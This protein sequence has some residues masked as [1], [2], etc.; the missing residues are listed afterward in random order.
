MEKRKFDSFAEASRFARDVSTAS[1]SAVVHRFDG[2][3]EVEYQSSDRAD[4]RAHAGHLDIQQL[5]HEL[6]DCRVLNESLLQ[7][8][9]G[10]EKSIEYKD[11]IIADI[12]REIENRVSDETS[13]EREEIKESERKRKDDYE[14]LIAKFEKER[15]E[16]IDGLRKQEEELKQKE[17]E[18]RS[19][20]CEYQDALERFDLL[21]EAY[22]KR[23]GKAEVEE[24]QHS[25]TTKEICHLCMGNSS[26]TGQ[27][28]IC[29]GTGW[30]EKKIFETERRVRFE[31]EASS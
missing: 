17:I 2:G 24:F 7:R 25:T 18:F 8:I 16:V 1:A 31:G 23:F 11:Q 22:A 30:E 21:L 20:S 6:E 19:L 12:E 9:S 4:N 5:A 26:G 29:D 14:K 3:F 15:A 28:R 27:C 10:L 13:L